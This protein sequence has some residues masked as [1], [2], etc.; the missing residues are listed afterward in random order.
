MAT[1]AEQL[2][3]TGSTLDIESGSGS[4]GH[5]ATLDG[6][7]VINQGALDIGD[8]NF[9]AILTLEDSTNFIGLGTMAI[10]AGSTLDAVSGVSTI[11]LV[12]AITNTGVL[13]ASAGGT[14]IVASNINNTSGQ[15]EATSGGTLEVETKISGG[16]A[17]IQGRHASLRCKKS[18]VNVT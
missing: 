3:C 4:S 11:I 9:G 2:R 12:G 16:S 10:K 15:L 13:E 17:A 5:G 6:I 14:L 8:V 7:N 18:N 1:A